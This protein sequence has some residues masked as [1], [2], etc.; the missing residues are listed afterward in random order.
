MKIKYKIMSLAIIGILLT[1]AILFVTVFVQKSKINEQVTEELLNQANRE[2]RTIA[3]DVY[4]MLDSQHQLL[5]Q[6]VKTDLN[7]AEEVINTQGNISFGASTVSW[8]AVNQY[9]KDG[10]TVELPR[11]VVGNQWLGQNDDSDKRSPVVDKIQDLVGGTCT[12]FQ[13]MNEE[14]D[15]LRVSTNVEKL[16]GTRAI[17][18]YIPATNPDGK[19]NPV[20][21]KVL[22][23]ETYYGRAYVVNAWYLTAYK[24]IFDK[25]DKVVGILYVGVKQE[26]ID[27]IREGIMDIVVGKTGYVFILG[28]KGD[29][30]GEVI[31][32]KFPER[33]GKNIYN[34]EDAN[35]KLYIQDMV[36]NAVNLEGDEVHFVNYFWQRYDDQPP[37]KKIAAIGYF[38][39]WD[40]VIG[41]GA[42]EKDFMDAVENVNQ[43]LAQLIYFF[44]VGV[45]ISIIVIGGVVILFARR[46]VKPINNA[47]RRLEDIAQGEGDLTQRLEVVSNDELGVMSKWF[48][49]FI[50]KIQNMISEISDNTNTI[51]ASGTELNA[52]AEEMSRGTQQ[53][54]EKANSVA[55]AAEE[56][57]SNM[58]TVNSSME[59]TNENLNTVAS[60][61]EEMS[62]S[63]NEIADNAS[64]STEITKSAVSQAKKASNQVNELGKAAQEIVKVT[65]TIAEISDQ[66]N[67]LALNA[68]IEAARAG[69][70]GKGF[71]VV[72]NEIKELAR[73][74]AEATEEIAQKLNGVQ[75]TSQD[76]A[77]EITSITEIINEIDHIVGAIAA[78]V[79][80]Q[81]ATTSENAQKINTIS[82]NMREISENVNQSSRAS[83]TIAEEIAEVNDSSNEMGNSASQ[84]QL[85][86][87]ELSKLVQKLKIMVGQFKI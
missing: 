55:A 44:I 63:I 68:T 10:T 80:Q 54:V 77:T 69:D 85:S 74:T 48:N 35:G 86:A 30:K 73:Q 23:G 15:M 25:N 78:A 1:A 87:D 81:N 67:L 34:N 61:T 56:M 21:S 79:E 9:T 76:T 57:S 28:G 27:A 65:D 7:V 2:T 71:A 64:K 53:T 40:W 26:S 51:A 3:Q 66:T 60:G 14:G 39:P 16:D 22:Q 72:A 59:E 52:I 36:D 13:R 19:A 43:N 42:Y 47:S 20:I 8:N 12:I 62:A 45:I 83:L 32:H 38:E 49:V 50:E 6:K 58:N 17:G 33:V 24:P 41:V 46:I 37:S 29:Q 75:S 5:M 84:V 4:R 31:I 18:T 70:A 82:G 11:M